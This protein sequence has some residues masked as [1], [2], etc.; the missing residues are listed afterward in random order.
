MIEPPPPVDLAALGHAVANARYAA[1]LTLDGLAERSG[2]SRRMLTEVE[3][4]R[5]NP[6]IGVL[7]AI[8]HAVDV[9]LGE[10]ASAACT[11]GAR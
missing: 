2:I 5:I 10:L 7:H 3:Q 11:D 8:A 4:G 6:S 9:P 1:G